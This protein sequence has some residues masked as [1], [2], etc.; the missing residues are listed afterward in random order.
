M[1]FKIG[2][3]WKSVNKGVADTA[4]LFF[5]KIHRINDFTKEI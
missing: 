4:L 2:N 5:Q 3:K 1:K